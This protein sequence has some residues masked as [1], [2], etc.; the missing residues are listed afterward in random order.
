MLKLIKKSSKKIGLPPGTLIHIGEKKA[1][2]VKLSVMRYSRDD[3]EE[4][5][6]KNEKESTKFI[7]DS[8]IT[9]INID[10]LH[11][12]AI[13]ENIGKH[14]KIH[15]L[16]LEDILNTAHRPKL[17]D[18][19]DYLFVVVKMLYFKEEEQEVVAEQ[20]SLILG[21]SYVL[22]F[23]EKEGD[24]FDPLR[25]RIKNGKGRVRKM[26]AD[27][28]AY[29]LLDAIVDHYFIILEK[30]GEKIEDL[31]EELLQ[32]PTPD[33]L[34][35]L[36]NLKREMIFL[37]KSTWPLRELVSGLERNE[38]SLVRE[39]TQ[40]FFRD[41]YDHTIQVID[42]V[43]TYRDVLNGML[44][45]YLSSVSNRMNE[46]MKTLTIIATIFIPL[47]FIAGIY[48]M[49]FKYMPELEWNWGYFAALGV[50]AAVTLIMFVYFRKK[51]WL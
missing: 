38:S 7:D 2:K 26:G 50:M 36:H 13:I 51:K 20:L 10:G 5:E 29:S 1:E 37:R 41:L 35:E 21:S 40:I 31:E 8:V 44:D 11:E 3:F 4:F 23:Q 49:N 33:T 25:D 12:T 43:E 28:L 45:T 32:A 34:A 14:Y 16:L 46:V 6:L 27:Y 39:P 48:G 42:T 17:E 18:F 47:T 22:T 9:W 15:P 19:D 30:L 24:V